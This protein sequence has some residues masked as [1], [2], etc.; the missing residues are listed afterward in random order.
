MW[1]GT[2]IAIVLSFY[3]IIKACEVLPSD[4]VYATFTG[5]GAQ[6]LLSLTSPYWEKLLYWQKDCISYLLLSV[7]LEFS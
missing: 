7:S 4:S 6:Q 5:S 1:T 2:I 3:F